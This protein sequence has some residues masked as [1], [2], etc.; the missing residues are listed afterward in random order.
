M[1]QYV[2]E[3]IQKAGND[4]DNLMIADIEV[5]NTS[6]RRAF[7]VQGFRE[8]DASKIQLKYGDT[9]KDYNTATPDT[10]VLFSQSCLPFARRRSAVRR[11][12]APPSSLS[13]GAFPWSLHNRRNGTRR[14]ART[15]WFASTAHE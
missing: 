3:V 4:M 11:Y 2:E 6:S 7:E 10:C 1:I 8:Q 5:D 12:T 14:S 15:H 13:L 9:W